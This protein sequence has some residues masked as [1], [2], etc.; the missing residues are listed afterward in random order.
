MTVAEGGEW[1]LM[2]LVVFVRTA[3]TVPCSSWWWWVTTPYWCSTWSAEGLVRGKCGVL[4]EGRH[5]GKNQ[6]T[7]CVAMYIG[8]P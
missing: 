2:V 6:I 7:T 4:A 5:N 8:L 1:D 3:V